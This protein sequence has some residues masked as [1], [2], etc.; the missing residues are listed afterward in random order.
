MEPE[1]PSMHPQPRDHSVLHL[2]TDH[3]SSIVWEVGGGDSQR[4]RHRNPNNVKF[5]PLHSR[6]VPILQDLS[7]D[8]VFRLTGI[9][10]YW[11]LITALIERWRPETHTFHFPIGEFFL[12]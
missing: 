10:I 9:Q 4:S 3:R 8:G 12:V 6:M 7:F 1:E 2:Q 11:S 5:L